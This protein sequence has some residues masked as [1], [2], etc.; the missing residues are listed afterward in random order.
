[1]ALTFA[2]DTSAVIRYIDNEPGHQRIRE[3][4]DLRENGDIALQICATHWS[5][6]IY[7]LLRRLR[8][9]SPDTV[10]RQLESLALDIVP[11]TQDRAMRAAQIRF[12]YSIPFADS[13]GVELA[14]TS[15]DHILITADF[16]VKPAAADFRIEFLPPKPKPAPIP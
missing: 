5:E 4:L 8:P 15:P 3:L 11:V 12:R 2:L 7:V 1:M 10:R 14:G 13:F 9:P 16:D 6:A